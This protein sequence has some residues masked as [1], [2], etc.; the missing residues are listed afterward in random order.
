M[1][2]RKTKKPDKTLFETAVHFTF[3]FI[4]HNKPA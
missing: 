1:K 3:V 4:F 2:N